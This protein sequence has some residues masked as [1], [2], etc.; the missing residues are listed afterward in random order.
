MLLKFFRNPK[1]IHYLLIFNLIHPDG[2]GDLGHLKDMFNRKR[3]DEYIENFLKEYDIHEV[4]IKPVYI[5]LHKNDPKVSDFVVSTLH[6]SGIMRR[7][8]DETVHLIPYKSLLGVQLS[9]VNYLR[10]KRS[11][12]RQSAQACSMLY[13]SR[14]LDSD[15]SFS[16]R[17]LSHNLIKPLS[18]FVGEHAVGTFPTPFLN[19]PKNRVMGFR[20]YQ[21]GILIHKPTFAPDSLSEEKAMDPVANKVH[22]MLSFEN[23]AYLHHL[24]SPYVDD[25]RKAITIETIKNIYS[26]IIFYSCLPSV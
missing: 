14:D 10:A 7:S 9:Y 12:V 3:I 19:N 1:S 23:K 25:K 16:P 21:H 18:T 5:I 26:V 20:D 2:L 6:L 11:L 13:V 24:L 4:L 8:N 22:A 17:N 15:F